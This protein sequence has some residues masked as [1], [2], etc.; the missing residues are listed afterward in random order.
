MSEETLIEQTVEAH[1]HHSHT[2]FFIVWGALLVLTGFEVF[3]AYEQLK[4]TTML[5]IL[6]V[7]SLVKA[8]L[9]IL[10]FMHMK[11]EK[12]SMRR[13]MMTA[14]VICLGLMSIFFEDALRIVHLGVH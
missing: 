11:F 8:A 12:A 5:S 10:Y 4:P 14:L 9:I 1:A 3:L 6:L 2:P 13:I 7:L